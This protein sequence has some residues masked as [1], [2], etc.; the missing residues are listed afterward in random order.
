MPAGIPDNSNE[1]SVD[2]QQLILDFN[3][4]SDTDGILT[5]TIPQGSRTYD[6]VLITGALKE[7][8]PSNYPT[9]SV[10]YTASANWAAPADRIGNAQVVGAF[11]RDKT[12]NTMTVTGLNADD[13][14]FFSAHLITNVRTYWSTG[15]RSYPQNIGSTVWAGSVDEHYGPP[16][17]PVAGQLYYDPDQNLVFVWDS[18]N[19]IWSVVTSNTCFSGAID[20]V[21]PFTGYPTGYPA[22]GNFYYNATVKKLKVWSGTEWLSAE[23]DVS[24]PMYNK[25]GVGTDS[26][27]T[28]RANLIDILKKQLGHPV[29]CVELIEDHFNIAIDNALQE[30][31]RRTDVAYYKQFF[32]ITIQASQDVY[33]LN[34]RTSQTDRIVDV[35]K[36]HRMNMLGAGSF[37]PDNI[38]ALQFLQQFYA[39]NVQADLVSIHLINAMSEIYNTLFASEIA[40]NWREATRELHIYRRLLNQEKVLIETTCEKFEQELLQDRWMQ[41]WIQA[42]AESECMLILAHIRG[43]FASLPGPGGGLQLNADS[44]LS[45]AQAIQEDCLRQIKDMEVGQNGS[46]NWFAPFVIG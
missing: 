34:D 1:L 19:S 5:W 33:Y 31:R 4:T 25:T 20:P 14:Y 15:V 3:R 10:K 12:T 44:L 9:D 42:W 26:S 23:S 28:A 6:G 17:S 46:D 41:Q 18:T 24:V 13:V 45:T 22:L 35:H 8:N 43:K 40:Y 39:P 27:Y 37:S 32:F 2:G 36:I 11:Y 21:S 30:I 16:A 7:I 38:Y 29:V